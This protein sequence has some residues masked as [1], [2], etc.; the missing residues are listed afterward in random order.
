M[1]KESEMVATLEEPARNVPEF[2][3]R[4]GV[5]ARDTKSSF[6]Y[7]L[8]AVFGFSFWFFMAVPLASHRETYSWLAGFKTQTLAH[9]LAYGLSSTYRPLAQVVTW[10]G[11]AIL[12]PNVFPTSVVRQSLLQVGVY[13]LFVL[14]W[15][16]IYT[17]S[18]E[19]RLFAVIACITGGV[20]FSGYIHLFHLY[21]M[22]YVP[23]ILMLGALL[24]VRAADGFHRRQE[25]WFAVAAL[26]LVLWHPFATA[27][28]LGFYFGFYLDSFRTRSLS[29]HVQAI[30]ILLTCT[31]AIGFFVVLYPRAR[32]PLDTK[33]FGFLVS[34]ETNEVNRI[35][36]AVAFVMTQLAI[37]SMRVSRAFKL[38]AIVVMALLGALLLMKSLP[39][40]FLWIGVGLFKVFRLRQ[41]SLFF[42]M[43]TATLLPLGGGIG[44]P[45]YALFAIILAA[46]ATVLGWEQAENALLFLKPRYVMGVIAAGAAVLLMIRADIQVPVLTKLASPL[47]AERE[48][49]YQLENAL[50][51]LH[52]SDYCGYQVGFVT[53]AGSPVDDVESAMN[54]WGRP[55]SALDDVQLYWNSVLRCSRN[56]YPVD[57]SPTATVTFGGAEV[58]GSR[59]VY[60]VKGKYAGDAAVWVADAPNRD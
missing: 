46:Y 19:R 26:V 14:A 39:V 49:T 41:W 12:N 54:R 44:T 25:A 33:L 24:R 45:M 60:R 48:R 29:Q 51:W 47:L 42:L 57:G 20:F 2:I 53:N 40:L 3:R 56:V 9:Q 10:S 37:V 35:A 38:A 6:V 34:Y 36:S 43:L 58:P 52:N 11:F 1:T 32:M 28:F 4:N 27:L 13:A 23:V 18:T 7:F 22:F 50:A 5:L 16:L 59:F 8:L 15:W 21:G 55:P 17:A 30:A 31:M